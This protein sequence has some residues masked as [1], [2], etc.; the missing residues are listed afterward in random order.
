M[1]RCL[2]L[3]LLLAFVSCKVY[4][5]SSGSDFNTGTRLSPIATFRRAFE[6]ENAGDIE[7]VVI[8]N[9]TWSGTANRG[10]VVRNRVTSVYAE[11]GLTA[12]I[13]CLHENAPNGDFRDMD[14]RDRF[15]LINGGTLYIRNLAFMHGSRLDDGG[16]LHVTGAAAT[17]EDCDF[18]MSYSHRGSGLFAT[19]LQ[20]LSFRNN[21]I[22]DYPAGAS[23]IH[24]KMTL[25]SSSAKRNL[26]IESNVFLRARSPIVVDGTFAADRGSLNRQ[27]PIL[28]SISNNAFICGGIGTCGSS[29]IDNIFITIRGDGYLVDG[30]TFDQFLAHAVQATGFHV[31]RN[32]IFTNGQNSTVNPAVG[33]SKAAAIINGP[34][35]YENLTVENSPCG[36]WVIQNLLSLSG[37]TAKAY[38][39][40]VTFRDNGACNDGTPGIQIEHIN[41][42]V[43][44]QDC[45]FEGLKGSRRDFAAAITTVE[46]SSVDSGQLYISNST[47]TNVEAHR[48]AVLIYN[49]T[50]VASKFEHCRA[51]LDEDKA[52]PITDIERLQGLDFTLALCPTTI[53]NIFVQLCKNEGDDIEQLK[54]FSFPL[55]KGGSIYVAH[56]Q[57]RYTAQVEDCS[58]KNS[59]TFQGIFS[60]NDNG[61][62]IEN[63][64]Y[65]EHQGGA[66]YIENWPDT[67][68][69][70]VEPYIFRNLEITESTSGRGGAIFIAHP[71]LRPS[72]FDTGFCKHCKFDNNKAITYGKNIATYEYQL[73]VDFPDKVENEHSERLRIVVVDAYDH[74]VPVFQN[75]SLVYKTAADTIGTIHGWS[76]DYLLELGEL[77]TEIE[78]LGVLGEELHFSFVS[79]NGLVSESLEVMIKE[80][81][82]G[83]YEKI[84]ISKES[85]VRVCSEQS[86]RSIMST[87]SQWIWGALTGFGILLCLSF[88]IAVYVNRSTR[89]IR[90]STPSFC[91]LILLGHLTAYVTVMTLIARPTD[92][93]C[94]AQ[95]WLFSLSFLL[96][97]VPLLVKNIRMYR[98]AHNTKLKILSIT[99][100]QLFLPLGMLLLVQVLVLVFW[101]IFSMPEADT[102][103]NTE[104]DEVF[105]T[106]TSEYSMLFTIISVVY[107][108][109]L[110]VVATYFSWT[111]RKLKVTFK[112]SVHVSLAVYTIGFAGLIFFPLIHLQSDHQDVSNMVAAVWFVVNTI[113]MLILFVPKFYYLRSPNMSSSLFTGASQFTEPAF[114]APSTESSL[115]HGDSS[116]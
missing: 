39:K 82:S 20:S 74:A 96:L 73:L 62:I 7:I 113:V 15:L 6:L 5:S 36:F 108:G 55:F 34:G 24:I 78:L 89:V 9:G 27:S 70:S 86:T 95:P 56:H 4:V 11:D 116:S 85:P 51:A 100:T 81:N 25:P 54:V 105:E 63:Q 71:V 92:E 98:F 14:T 111:T 84:V 2:A 91:L 1:I 16:I 107:C 35:Y 12:T 93:S 43:E 22:H 110:V 76:T 79:E 38:F 49:S 8:S 47:F 29:K 72:F 99:T 26:K 102:T 97:I 60:F 50:I 28:L 17:I 101:M 41:H 10:F 46:G 114:L 77:E 53:G 115:L 112:E 58:F 88:M 57:L 23:I 94:R 109:V 18:S 65:G 90:F 80:C 69:S 31:I 87:T 21:Y 83:E 64:F 59:S 13:D 52:G 32:C 61:T 106:C 75:Y 103:S 44:V 45:H 104:S 67:Q 37:T 19:A 40:N 33:D 48:G 3:F 42:E 68:L 66:I 30:N